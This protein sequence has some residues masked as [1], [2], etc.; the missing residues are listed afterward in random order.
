MINTYNISIFRIMCG[1]LAIISKNKKLDE[2]K[3]LRSLK[4]LGLR[5]PDKTL[6]NFFEKNKIFI[7]N[8][9]LNITGK[10]KK[11][12][13]LYSN[14]HKKYF[15]SYNGEIYNFKNLGLNE[16]KIKKLSS[17]DT[18]V[19]LEL[20]NKKKLN[21]LLKLIDGM[22][23]MII[24]NNQKKI[25]NFIT[26]PQGEKKLLKY[27][28]KN[29]IIICSTLKPIFTYLSKTKC[30]DENIL[31]EYFYTRHLMMPKKTVYKNIGFLTPGINYSYNFKNKKFSKKYYDDPIHWIDEKKYK[32]YKNLGLDKS[33]LLLENEI[34]KTLQKMT[35]FIN[36]GN[37]FSGGVDSSLISLFLQKQKKSKKLIFIDNVKKDPISNKIKLFK[38]FINFRKLRIFKMNKKIYYQNLKKTYQNIEMPFLSHELVGRNKVFEF[39]KNSNLKVCFGGDGADEIF[40]GYK[41]YEKIDWRKNS[42]KNFSPYS[43]Y[44]KNLKGE[45]YKYSNSLWKRA[46][47]KYNKFLNSSESKI[48]ASL[49]ADYFAQCVGVHNISNDLLSG[50]NSVEIRNLFMNK[51]II[52][53]GINLPLDYKINLKNQNS[54]LKTKVILK[55]I[56]IKN[57]SKKLLFEKQGFSGFPNE[58]L[59]IL[60]KFEKL[61]FSK[62]HSIF[63]G[64]FKDKNRAVEWKLLNIF[65]FKKYVSLDKKFLSNN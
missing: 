52:K 18:S 59:D 16:D 54:K 34:K 37:I 61:K 31:K 36:F 48:Q 57:F 19:F 12:L 38:K 53:I 63:K 62:L 56:F 14:L 9:I 1:V 17:K 20:L 3:C 55:K 33:S 28:D 23:S 46:Y 45:N 51:N 25:F 8:T 47:K 65:F 4:T 29:I 39:F 13:N 58:T 40:G 7:G 24:Y 32:V 42:I 43:C 35:P 50:E 10:L 49:F 27:E 15:I 6:F 30:I 41:L 11:D 22:F 26:D 21:N 64:Y 60:N 44:L 2:K 5:G